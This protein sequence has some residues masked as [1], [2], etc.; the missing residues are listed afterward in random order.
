MQIYVGVLAATNCQLLCVTECVRSMRVQFGLVTRTY[1][2]H[3]HVILMC[4]SYS[5]V[6]FI[7]RALRELSL[8]ASTSNSSKIE[9][10]LDASP[11][12]IYEATYAVILWQT[13][14]SS[15]IFL[16]LPLTALRGKAGVFWAVYLMQAGNPRVCAYWAP[17]RSVAFCQLQSAAT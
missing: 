14:R 15:Y 17:T 8:R 2:Y 4:Q 13:P 9:P 6:K 3:S 5:K 11:L 16:D 1:W 12:E 10:K 7:D